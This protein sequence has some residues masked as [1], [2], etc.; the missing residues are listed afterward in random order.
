[1]TTIDAQARQ[2]LKLFQQ[3]FEPFFLDYLS[4]KKRS[5]D[6]FTTDTLGVHDLISD[7][8]TRQAKRLRASFAYFVYK[9]CGGTDEQPPLQLGIFLELIHTYLLIIDDIMDQGTLRRGQPTAHQHFEQAF[10]NLSHNNYSR[11]H[12]EHFGISIAMN[13]GVLACHYAYELLADIDLSNQSRDRI[14]RLSNQNLTKTGYGQIRDITN[15]ILAEISEDEIFE[16]LSLKSGIYTYS[17]PIAIG[18]LAAGVSDKH[19]LQQL[20]NYAIPGG[21][22]FQIQDDIIGM[23]SETDEM[24]KSSLDDMREG[25]F[26]LLVQHSFAHADA[27]QTHILNSVLGNPEATQEDLLTLRELMKDLG[28]YDYARSKAQEL[29]DQALAALDT[30]PDSWNSEGIDYLRGISTYVINRNK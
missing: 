25:K 18:A 20:E 22:A 27:S 14:L 13:A 26:T 4:Q 29:T 12:A 21:I 19:S 10:P 6:A 23:F 2:E 24:G 17:N 28:S 5:I 9:M 7:L 8:S 1:M 11:T 16:T 3:K 15:S 30:L